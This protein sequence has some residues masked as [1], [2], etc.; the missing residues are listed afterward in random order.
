M[1]LDKPQIQSVSPLPF[2]I[3]V[4]AFSIRVSIVLDCFAEVK[5][6]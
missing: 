4:I 3:L 5:N 2:N 6:K 1:R